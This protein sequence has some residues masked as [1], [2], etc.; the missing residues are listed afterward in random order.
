[1][2]EKKKL[3][4]ITLA[5]LLVVNSVFLAVYFLYFSPS[6]DKDDAATA[7]ALSASTTQKQAGNETADA[8]EV[9]PLDA[10]YS[11]HFNFGDAVDLC[12]NEARSRNKNLVQLV[13]NEH[14]SRFNETDNRYLIKLDSYVGTPMLY[15][16]KQH[17]CEIDPETQGVAFYKEIVRRTAVR[18]KG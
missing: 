17:T 11:V 8:A 12:M 1:M 15:D 3:I 4:I 14:S 7:A 18:P 5:T 9:N 16:E 2:S 6:V 13:L 10:Y